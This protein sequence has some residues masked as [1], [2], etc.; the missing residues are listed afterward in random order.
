MKKST[1]ITTIAM[2]VVVVVA[3]STATYAWFST[4]T[5]AVA[6][7]ELSTGA[8]ADFVL[9]EG[10]VTGSAATFTGISTDTITLK[11]ITLASGVDTKSGLWAPTAKLT[12]TMTNESVDVANITTPSYSV[13]QLQTKDTVKSNY[14]TT[15]PSVGTP[16][17]IRVGN[18]SG[19][20]KGLILTIVVNAG[21]IQT[22]GSL[23]AAVAT[24]FV[25]DYVKSGEDG[26]AGNIVT[27]GYNYQSAAAIGDKVA[28]PTLESGTSFTYAAKKS[29]VSWD[30]DGSKSVN[31]YS[32]PPYANATAK[33]GSTYDYFKQNGANPNESFGLQANDYY[34]SYTI[35]LG[36]L[37]STEYMTLALYTWIDGFVAQAAAANAQYKITYAFT[38]YEVS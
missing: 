18:A 38:S 32:R 27:N 4:S 13:G 15:A 29:C 1:L 2:I 12:A 30:E 20:N 10:S 7:T 21:S 25:V 33:T 26:T 31:T 16:D 28:S 6:T 9:Y 37:T 22:T 14:L 19:A 24:S 3:L 11:G 8:S 5:Y 36:T 17:V 34:L 35:D 23:Y